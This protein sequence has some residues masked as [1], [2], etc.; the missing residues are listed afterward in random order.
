[1]P[2]VASLS[3]Q[4]ASMEEISMDTTVLIIGG[5]WS[6]MKVAQEVIDMG[7]GVVL[8]EA[9]AGVGGEPAGHQSASVKEKELPALLDSVKEADGMEI[10]TATTLVSLT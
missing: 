6:G 10:L 2:E 4:R 5:G 8:A 1:M 3:G 7:Y 9:G